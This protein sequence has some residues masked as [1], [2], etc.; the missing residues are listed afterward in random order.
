M[1]ADEK[2]TNQPESF[3]FSAENRAKVAAIIA[4]Y[5]KG[6]EASAVLPLLHLAQEQHDNWLPAAAMD[7]VAELLGMPHVRVY[8][9]ASFYTMF[10]TAPMGR[11]HIKVCTTTPCALRGATEIVGTLR[12]RL[13]IEVGATTKDGLFTIDEVEC[14]GNC[15]CAPVVQINDHNHNNVDNNQLESLLDN[16][17]QPH[18]ET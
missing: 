2:N 11:H 1:A 17:S 13:G 5:P 7:H 18:K 9:V 14:L 4:K 10:N 16:L 3:S 8:E 6:R 15:T 12:K